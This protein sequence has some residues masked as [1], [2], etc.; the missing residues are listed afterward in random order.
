[1]LARL[2]ALR[3]ALHG[4]TSDVPYPKSP[5]PLRVNFRTPPFSPRMAAHGFARQPRKASG[6]KS[7]IRGLRDKETNGIR[8][9]QDKHI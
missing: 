4:T 7:Y 1:M 3:V 6:K 5:M 2:V 8:L 9:T